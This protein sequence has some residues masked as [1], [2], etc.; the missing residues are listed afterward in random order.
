MLLKPSDLKLLVQA[1]LVT[2]E[3]EIGCD[4]CLDRVA[5]YAEVHLAGLPTPEALRLVEEHLAICGE[6]QEEFAALAAALDEG[7][8]R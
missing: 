5:A 2:R 6:C 3:Q 1:T 7:A 8:A 4:T